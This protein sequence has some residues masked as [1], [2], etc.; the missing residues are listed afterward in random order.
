MSKYT[1]NDNGLDRPMTVEETKQYEATVAAY[2][3][4]QAKLAEETAAAVEARKAPLRRIG[5]T[6]D[7]INTVLGL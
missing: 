5:L 3:A 7:E 2:E 6:D 1:I 4:D